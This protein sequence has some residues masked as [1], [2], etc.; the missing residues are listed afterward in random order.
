MSS[1][2]RFRLA[3]DSSSSGFEVALGEIC[4][5]GKRG[6]WIWYVFPQLSGLGSSGSAS[7]FG[8]AG[9]REA[10]EFLRDPE[11][12]S[13]LLAIATAVMDQLRTD[14]TRS[15]R[16]LMGSDLDARKLVSSMTLFGHVARKLHETDRLDAYNSMATVADT[17]LAE[18]ARQGY[19]PCAFTLGRLRSAT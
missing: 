6:H 15:L 10:A 2:E 9:E 13:R 7:M 1:L 16:V 4:A 18:A 8:V 3:Q 12:R 17:I 19:P 5:G 14:A 11:L